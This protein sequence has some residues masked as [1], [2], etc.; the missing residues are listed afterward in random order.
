MDVPAAISRNN[1]G[2]GAALDQGHGSSSPLTDQF[3]KISDTEKPLVLET[4]A[5]AMDELIRL[6]RINEPL[7]IKSPADGGFVLHRDSYEKIF[8][9]AD[10]FTNS[11]ARVEASKDSEIVTMNAMHLVEMILNS[12]SIH[13]FFS[14]HI[15]YTVTLILKV[16]IFMERCQIK[17][18]IQFCRIN[19]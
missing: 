19:G 10:H 11:T 7:W 1:Q 16:S 18:S 8:P 9:R 3:K 14:F 5:S 17:Q 6:I 15:S 13:D 12:V 2:P 4:A